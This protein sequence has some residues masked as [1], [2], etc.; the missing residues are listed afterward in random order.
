MRV[1]VRSEKQPSNCRT[2]STQSQ[3]KNRLDHKFVGW[4]ELVD[5][6][7]DEF[8]VP[9]STQGSGTLESRVVV[10]LRRYLETSTPTITEDITTDCW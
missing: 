6:L 8:F 3:P 10:G 1:G 4:W 2:A 9:H 5:R 7:P